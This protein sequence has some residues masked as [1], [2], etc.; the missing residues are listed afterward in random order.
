MLTNY[1]NTFESTIENQIMCKKAFKN[2]ETIVLNIIF[3]IIIMVPT[4]LY[5]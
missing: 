4:N 1:S 2:S 3:V 5:K